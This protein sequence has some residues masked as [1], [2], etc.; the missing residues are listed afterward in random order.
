MQVNESGIFHAERYSN[1]MRQFLLRRKKAFL[2][3]WNEI[4]SVLKYVVESKSPSPSRKP[5]DGEA[6]TKTEAVAFALRRGR[7]FF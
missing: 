7:S 1:L 5:R 2:S 4:L 3:R 6:S